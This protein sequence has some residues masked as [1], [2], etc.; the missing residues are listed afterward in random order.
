MLICGHPYVDIWAAI[1]PATIGIAA[2]PDVE[3]GRPWKEGVIESLG[4]DV[5]SGR[6]WAGV[7]DAV[8]SYRDIEKPLVN[9]VEQLID[10]VT[11]D[12]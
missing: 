9:A 2:W 8:T 7:L 4:M 12:D 6:F 1:K 11:V 3:P 5:A 10:F